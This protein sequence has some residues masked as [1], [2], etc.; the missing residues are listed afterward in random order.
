[1]AD[2][3][4]ISGARGAYR[5]KPSWKVIWGLII[6]ICKKQ[7]PSFTDGFQSYKFI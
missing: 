2:R 1:M 5:Y 6:M 7:S 3:G 4:Q